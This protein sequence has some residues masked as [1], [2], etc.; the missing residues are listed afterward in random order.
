MFQPHACL[1]LAKYCKNKGYNIWLYTGFTYEE[2]IKMS[3]KDTVYKDILKY[4]DVLVD[5]RFI[6]KEK[7]LSYLF[8][9]SRN[10]R[11]IDIPN[12][13]KENKV[14]LFNESEYLE[15]NKYKKPNTYI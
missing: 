11:L 7:D 12:T 1:E 9:G 2:L 3:E 6:L 15:E 14:I 10:Q 13:L 5:G 4:I 8:R